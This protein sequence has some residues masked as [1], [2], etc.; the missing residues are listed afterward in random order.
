M[1]PSSADVKAGALCCKKMQL[2]VHSAIQTNFSLFSSYSATSNLKFPTLFSAGFSRENFMYF[3]SPIKRKFI[4]PKLLLY[5]RSGFST[6][7]TLL[8]SAVWI[9]LMQPLCYKDMGDTVIIILKCSDTSLMDD[10][11]FNRLLLHVVFMKFPMS[12]F[13][14]DIRVISLHR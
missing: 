11:M 13:N 9:R 5:H 12:L 4:T 6:F 10:N 7:F 8:L 3:V 1:S 2:V 14:P